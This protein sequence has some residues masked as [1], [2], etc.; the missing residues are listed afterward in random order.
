MKTFNLIN[1][2]R[3]NPKMYIK[4]LQKLTSSFKGKTYRVPG[5][6][7]NVVTQ[8]GRY[9]VDDAIRFLKVINYIY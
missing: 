8:E 5:S 4:E 9:A 2:T 6:N 1:Q 7:V 3:M